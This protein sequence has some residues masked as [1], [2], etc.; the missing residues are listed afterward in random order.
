MAQASTELAE[1]NAAGR[2]AFV[3]ALGGVFE[4]APWVAERAWSGRPF[5]TVA[6]LHHALMAAL[7]GAKPRFAA[8]LTSLKRLIFPENKLS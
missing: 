2:D 4:N 7:T 6:D 3:A 1:L 5:A 8:A